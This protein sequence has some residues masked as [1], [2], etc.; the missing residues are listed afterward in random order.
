MKKLN[1]K[2]LMNQISKEWKEMKPAQKKVYNDRS[3][4][5]KLEHQMYKNSASKNEKIMNKLKPKQPVS[6]FTRFSC[7]ERKNNKDIFKGLGL[8]MSTKLLSEKWRNL[9]STLKQ[10][11]QQQYEIEK[12]QYKKEVE[13]F[14]IKIAKGEKFEKKKL[15]VHQPFIWYLKQTYSQLKLSNPGVTHQSLLKIVG[16]QWVSLSEEEKRIYY[17]KTAPIE[18]V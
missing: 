8:E 6:P 17:K 2:E 12:V 11:Y 3:K 10:S 7:N 14:K 4:S 9:D 15:A 1:S 5:F 16:Q 18:S 13:N